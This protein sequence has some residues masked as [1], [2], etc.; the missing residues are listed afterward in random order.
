V[1]VVRR[2]VLE[3]VEAPEFVNITEL[4]IVP[5]LF[6]VP[7]LLKPPTP[8]W[9]MLSVPLLLTVPELV[10]KQPPRAVIRHRHIYREKPDDRQFRVGRQNPREPTSRQDAV[11]RAVI[12]NADGIRLQLDVVGLDLTA[13]I[14]T[15]QVVE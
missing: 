6:S 4:L 9:V 11:V 5:V 15:R 10:M 14:D 13:L 7:E 1:L 12:Q 2:P 3:I 8:D